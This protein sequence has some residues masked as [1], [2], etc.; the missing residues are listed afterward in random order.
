MSV[1]QFVAEAAVTL[2]TFPTLIFVIVGFIVGMLFG[3]TPGVGGSLGLALALPLTL[4]FD[5]ADALVLL[6]VMYAGAMYGGA[7]SAIVLNVPGTGAAVA[8][9]FEGYPMAR[10]GEA[11]YALAV[12]ATS[13]ALG[14]IVGAVILIVLSAWLVT[15]V[16]MFGAPEYALVA[17]LGLALIPAISQHSPM[18]A[19]F[20]GGL[21]MMLATIGLA[22][23]APIYRYTFDVLMASDGISFIAVLLGLF[24]I[25]EMIRLGKEGGQIAKSGGLDSSE[26]FI[27]DTTRGITVAIR[28][29]VVILKSAVIGMIVGSVPGAGASVSNIVAYAEQVRA[30]P[31]LEWMT[32]E[33]SG[34]IAS[35]SSNNGTVG[36]SLVPVLSFGIPGS[37]S[38]AIILGGM[39]MHG[40]RPGPS[41]FD[42]E[43]ELGLTILIFTSII[44][45]SVLMMIIGIFII[46]RVD[47]LTRIDINIIIPMVLMLSVLGGF[48]LSLNFFD[49]FTVIFIGI[50]GYYMREYGFSII[51]F[52][53]GVILGP[54]VE[55]NLFRSLQ[56]G[57][58]SY[59]IFARG[60][61]SITLLILI[62]LVLA[63]PVWQTY[64]EK[65]K[66]AANA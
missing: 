12:S 52:L 17:I 42:A 65:K 3:M 19:L 41:L 63:I 22:P 21:G 61:L 66:G 32:G 26:N 59:T 38:S 2:V 50:L 5:G 24:A 20:A 14:G 36:G 9:T 18:K 16:L 62:V 7:I 53:M 55:E 31:D 33:V 6:T 37:G 49:V 48:T 8:S 40:L 58:F 23:M 13:S 57:G 10:K 43:G 60:P 51:A 44:A 39:L 56:M 35:E 27:G 45:A 30:K 28:H 15:A 25:S 1:T 46:T 29:P 11:H 34:L 47:Y 64:K 4:P 54:I